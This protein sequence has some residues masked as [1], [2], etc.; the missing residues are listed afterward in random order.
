MFAVLMSVVISH[1]TVDS[2]PSI[3]PQATYSSDQLLVKFKAETGAFVLAQSG[4]TDSLFGEGT[5]TEALSP[6]EPE[7]S[8]LISLNGKMSVEDAVAQASKDP[9]VEYAEPNFLCYKTDTP[10]NDPFFGEMWGLNN[11]GPS[12][13]SV[14]AGADIS[15]I[16]AWDL[17]T[18]SEAVVV[19]V[20][21]TGAYLQHVD[22]ASNAWVNPREIR[23]NGLDDDANGLVD[24]VNGWN[25]FANNNR[26]Y[27]DPD[28]DGHGTHVAGTIGAVGNNGLG[29]TGVAWQVKLMSLKFLDKTP[30]SIDGAVRAINYAIEQ[31]R[32]GVNVRCDQRQLDLIG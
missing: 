8:F 1:V 22:L 20:I 18:G 26:V 6:A 12:T 14:K 9:R 7:G 13:S 32:R 24:D 5:S 23:G 15:A 28:A 11:S 27:T 21:D 31:K 17:T 10:P 2:T 3:E 30:G 4:T 25:F 16:R 19:A 29:V